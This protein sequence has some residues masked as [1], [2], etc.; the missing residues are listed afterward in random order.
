[1][2][3][4][5]TLTLRHNEINIMLNYSLEYM[6]CIS[7]K[8]RLENILKSPMLL[9]CWSGAAR[10][11]KELGLALPALVSQYA[12]AE[13]GAPRARFYPAAARPAPAYQKLSPVLL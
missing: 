4:I 11:R 1:M 8:L 2:Y 6:T 9:H 12:L 13:S 7:F 5:I 10:A 3:V